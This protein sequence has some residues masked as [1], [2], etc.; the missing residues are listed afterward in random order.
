VLLLYLLR[1]LLKFG[2]LSFS[3]AV[4]TSTSAGGDPPPDYL[5][6][7]TP[8]VNVPSILATGLK[9]SIKVPGVPSSDAQ[10]G[11]GQY[12][13]DLTPSQMASGTMFQV[14]AALFKS[15]W[16]WG[17]RTRYDIGYIMIDVRG[18]PVTRVAPLFTKTFGNKGIWLNPTQY[19]L[20]LIGRVP[21]G[22]IGVVSFKPA[23]SDV[24]P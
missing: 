2:L 13:T 6:H 10:W 16:R 22:G 4:A 19:N 5:Y 21:A 23:P 1:W 14:S 24:W 15:P 8:I 18:L 7:Y 3:S 12:L 20:P 11:D 9:P 17:N